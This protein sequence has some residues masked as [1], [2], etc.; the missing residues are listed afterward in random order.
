MSLL[1]RDSSS[2]CWP[3]TSSTSST[4]SVFFDF[5]GT[6]RV[7]WALHVS[8]VQWETHQGLRRWWNTRRKTYYGSCVLVVIVD[9]STAETSSGCLSVRVYAVFYS[10]NIIITHLAHIDR[11]LFHNQLLIFVN[12]LPFSL[13]SNIICCSALLCVKQTYTSIHLCPFLCYTKC[14]K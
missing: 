6:R 8:Y 4:S 13:S 9:F 10:V 7:F 11:S 2:L 12:S 14:C 5:R 1:P 3:C